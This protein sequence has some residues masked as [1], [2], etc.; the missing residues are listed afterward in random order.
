MSPERDSDR[1]V[2]G[3]DKSLGCSRRVPN[4]PTSEQL[5]QFLYQASVQGLSVLVTFKAKVSA[6]II[7]YTPV[8][9]SLHRRDP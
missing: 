4:K 3:I 9:E 1:E 7:D 2:A 8:D 6:A 5:I